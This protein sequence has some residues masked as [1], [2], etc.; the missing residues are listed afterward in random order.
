MNAE[1]SDRGLCIGRPPET[2]ETIEFQRA[3]DSS[4]NG[5]VSLKRTESKMDDRQQDTGEYTII[6]DVADNLHGE[7]RRHTNKRGNKALRVE[8]FVQGKTSQAPSFN[9]ARPDRYTK[10]Q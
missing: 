2:Y 4:T 8:S 6:D 5:K 10:E 3:T 7:Y 1:A 9:N